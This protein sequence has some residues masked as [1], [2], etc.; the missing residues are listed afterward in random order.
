MLG[1]SPTAHHVKS[2]ETAIAITESLMDLEGAGVTELASHLGMAKS[3]IHDHLATLEYHGFVVKADGGY[4]LGLRFLDFGIHARDSLDIY[5]VAKS[6]VKELAEESKERAWC[7]V[8]ENGMGVFICGAV[9]ERTVRTDARIGL[10]M[11]L[12]CHAGGKAILASLPEDQVRSIIDRYGLP[13]RSEHTIT[14]EET[15]MAH[16]E[17]VRERGYAVNREESIPGIHAVSA[18]I[19]DTAGTVLGAVSVTGA[20]TRMP[21][22][23]IAGE[24]SEMVLAAANEIELNLAYA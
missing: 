12:H 9:G 4:R 8:E 22:S 7:E 14:D 3:T 18:P 16:L 24:I 17:T 11:P 1:G 5:G 13:R 23:R 10:R 2:D 21:E 6:K 19:T 15:L 20:A